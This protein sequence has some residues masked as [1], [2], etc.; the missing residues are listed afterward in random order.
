MTRFESLLLLPQAPVWVDL[1]PA[2][3][4]SPLALVWG[5]LIVG[6]VWMGRF[7]LWISFWRL[8]HLVA[9][10][11]GRLAGRQTCCEVPT[12]STFCCAAFAR[13]EHKMHDPS[14]YCQH[15][16]CFFFWRGRAS[17]TAAAALGPYKKLRIT[18]V[19]RRSST[20][21][22]TA[23]KSLAKKGKRRLR[24]SYTAAC[25]FNRH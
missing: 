8:A 18:S 21:Q 15:C 11:L 17:V 1:S 7:S 12:P 9:A 4:L 3:A 14:C 25:R 24:T 22:T 23:S 19:T 20:R 16:L 5:I 6:I 2:A 10:L 13:S